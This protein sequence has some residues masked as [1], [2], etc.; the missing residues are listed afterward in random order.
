[1]TS[2]AA[3]VLS[4]TSRSG[5]LG[6]PALA[7]AARAPR[8]G[9]RGEARRGDA[10]GGDGGPGRAKPRRGSAHS[11]RR[12]GKARERREPPE[13]PLRPGRDRAPTPSIPSLAATP[14]QGRDRPCGGTRGTSLLLNVPRASKR[15]LNQRRICPSTAPAGFGT[16]ERTH[17]SG[18]IAVFWWR[19]AGAGV[20]VEVPSQVSV[21]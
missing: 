18:V 1:M 10:G 5:P 20:G 11:E 19:G 16:G 4:Y 8:S 15:D 17:V 3:A 21:S 6:D 13:P 2:T 9:G 14:T 12:A 7:R